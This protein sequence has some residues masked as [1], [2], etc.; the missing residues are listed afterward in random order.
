MSCRFNPGGLFQLSNGIMDNP[1]DSKYG[2]TTE[3]LFDAFRM[4]KAKGAE[5]FGIH[6][7]LAS[8]TVTNDYYPKLARILF[9]LAVRLERETGAHVAFINL[10]GGVGIPTCPSSRPMTSTPSARVYT[11]PT[12]R[13]WFPPAWAMW[14]SAPRWA[15]L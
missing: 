11:R 9:E 12:T 4:L 3:Q 8:N 5:D 10:S 2:M 14:R 13:S 1:G 15:A 7:F 6:A